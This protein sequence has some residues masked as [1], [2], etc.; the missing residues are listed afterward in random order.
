MKRNQSRH[1]LPSTLQKATR[2]QQ[3][4]IG[5]EASVLS[6][7]EVW[8]PSRVGICT[9]TADTPTSTVQNDML[10]CAMG[11]VLCQRI[12]NPQCKQALCH[13]C[14]Y[15]NP[16]L[17]PFRLPEQSVAAVEPVEGV[18]NPTEQLLQA[19]PLGPPAEYCPR[20]QMSHALPP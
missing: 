20:G 13:G 17:Y 2:R 5:V 3:D 9:A 19:V 12:R 18:V 11:F 1:N 14:V 10:H 15:R 16:T 4:I 7:P 6:S 8:Q